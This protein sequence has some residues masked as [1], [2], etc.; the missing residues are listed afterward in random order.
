[1]SEGEMQR[2]MGRLESRMTSVENDL[3]DIK[4][5]TRTILDT[6][7]QAKGGWKTLVLVASIAGTMGALAAK[8]L[9]FIPVK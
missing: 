4:R 3:S 6:L 7:A 2:D 1:M 8:L 5:D 9:P